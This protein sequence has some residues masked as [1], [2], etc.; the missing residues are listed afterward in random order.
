MKL[1]SISHLVDERNHK[2]GLTTFF[3]YGF[4]AC[5]VAR[6]VSD[7]AIGRWGIATGNLYAYRKM[8][9][10]PLLPPAVVV[11]EWALLLAAALAL[12]VRGINRRLIGV[13]TL[14]VG[15]LSLTQMFQH[16]KLLL[17]ACSFIMAIVPLSEP[18]LFRFAIRAQIILVYL[19]SVLSKILTGF[20]S[21]EDLIRAIDY[22]VSGSLWRS[23]VLADIWGVLRGLPIGVLT[24]VAEAL[25]VVLLLWR[26]NQ[27]FVAMIAL[28]LAMALL[29]ADVLPFSLLMIA[30]GAYF[31]C[32]PTAA[33]NEAA[34]S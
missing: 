4:S 20:A 21:S 5:L 10:F 34:P 32:S 8:V 30:M 25:V 27:G 7:I 6:V 24:L 1:S 28:H 18:K 19:G 31:Y 12:C 15:L 33:L 11:L 13:V 22:S 2:T 23:V 17:I 9:G 16:Q 14:F 26:P 29:L 3:A